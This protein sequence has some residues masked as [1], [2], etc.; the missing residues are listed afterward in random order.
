MIGA[1]EQCGH[2]GILVRLFFRRERIS[3]NAAIPPKVSSSAR[4]VSDATLV[5]QH[6]LAILLHG[7]FRH[8]FSESEDTRE[9]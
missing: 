2:D 9:V 4:A 8:G 5:D 7:V 3:A 1:H 6:F